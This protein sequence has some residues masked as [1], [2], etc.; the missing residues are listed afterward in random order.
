[1]CSGQQ[2]DASVCV[3]RDFVQT[4]KQSSYPFYGYK[5]VPC[6]PFKEIY[7]FVSR[8][9]MVVDRKKAIVETLQHGD[10]IGKMHINFI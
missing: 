6:E 5:R 9:S 1:M 4:I 3:S 2:Y 7:P 10:V 8:Q